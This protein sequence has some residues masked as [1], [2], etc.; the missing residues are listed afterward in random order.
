MLACDFIKGALDA[1]LYESG[2]K[3][4]GEKWGDSILHNLSLLL[5]ERQGQR[6]LKLPHNCTHRTR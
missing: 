1:N 5:K 6:M 3:K 4:G 2:S